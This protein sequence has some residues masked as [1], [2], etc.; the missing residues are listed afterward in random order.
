MRSQRHQEE[1]SSSKDEATSV[2]GS[3]RRGGKKI[4]NCQ[5]GKGTG[6][7]VSPSGPSKKVT[8]RWD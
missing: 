4:R 6:Q 1:K 8:P 2:K 7:C 5:V 3:W